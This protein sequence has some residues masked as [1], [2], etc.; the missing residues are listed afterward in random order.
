MQSRKLAVFVLFALTSLAHGAESRRNDFDNGLSAE[1][2][3]TTDLMKE[4]DNLSLNSEAPVTTVEDKSSSFVSVSAGVLTGGSLT[5]NTN[6]IGI[7]YNLNRAI[8]ILGVSY[9][10]FPESQHH[11]WGNLGLEF[12]LGYAYSEYN[13]AQSTSLN[14]IPIEE[15][16]AYRYEKNTAQAWVPFAKAGPSEWIWVQRGVDQLNNSA[17]AFGGEIAAGISL[18]LRAIGLASPRE[19]PEVFFDIQRNIFGSGNYDFN[20]TAFRLGA[21]IAL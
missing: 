6:G 8:P 2:D 10:Y 21:V 14:I 12:T 7:N 15:A 17:A 1:P 19:N 20:G 9:A 18:K 5:T 16:I 13:L 3:N 4:T 11:Q